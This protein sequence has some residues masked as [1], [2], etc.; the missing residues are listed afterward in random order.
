M[1]KHVLK[2]LTPIVWRLYA[3]VATSWFLLFISRNALTQS[4]K[5]KHYYLRENIVSK[6]PFFLPRVS[7][8]TSY[9]TSFSR[10][11]FFSVSG[12][13]VIDPLPAAYRR[14]K[15]HP[16]TLE[17]R[18]RIAGGT[19]TPPPSPPYIFLTLAYTCRILR[20]VLSYSVWSCIRWVHKYYKACMTRYRWHLNNPR[21]FYNVH[22]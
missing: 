6:I 5:L 12:G 20:Y 16:V 2:C 14:W 8:V 17:A 7:Q 22:I 13:N 3:C 10:R 4:H 21:R 11:G 15:P 19:T 18:I 9:R 1:H